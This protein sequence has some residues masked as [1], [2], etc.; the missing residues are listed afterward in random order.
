MSL[1]HRFSRGPKARSEVADLV[2]VLSDEPASSPLEVSRR[3]EA[4]EA[5]AALGEKAYPALPAI[6]RALWIRV[7]VDNALWLRIAAAEAAWKVGGLRD[8][9][10]P[11]IAW[12][13]KDEY[14]GVARKAVMI[15]GEMGVSAHDASP[16]LMQVA[17]RLL[18]S[19][20][21]D[22]DVPAL[23]QRPLLAEV[24][25]TLGK[26]GR[27]RHWNAV[28]GTLSRI[29]GCND[30]SVREAAESAL[31][32]LGDPAKGFRVRKP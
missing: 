2:A 7:D 4:L 30:K 18:A 26:C 3:C 12:G 23:D 1:R 15:L 22:F 29:A 9:A 13:L 25:E 5:L 14:W 31:A 27:G 20:S 19:G 32:F 16:E 6:L 10:L 8:L 24:A 17:D 28:Y 11:I 21:L